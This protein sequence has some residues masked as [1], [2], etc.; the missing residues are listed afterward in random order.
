[1]R[2]LARDG[3]SPSLTSTA[4]VRVFVARN[5]FD[6]VF[7]TQNYTFDIQEDQSL[8]VNFG[9]LF[10]GDEDVSVSGV[11]LNIG[12]HWIYGFMELHCAIVY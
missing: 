7:T 9:Q 6:P 2:T 3:G 8:G 4:V 12:T 1:M 5:L 10:A 11:V